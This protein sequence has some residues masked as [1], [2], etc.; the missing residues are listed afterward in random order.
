MQCRH[1]SAVSQRQRHVCVRW[2][3]VSCITEHTDLSPKPVYARLQDV[4]F[5]RLVSLPHGVREHLQDQAAPLPLARNLLRWIARPAER[6]KFYG[7]VARLRKVCGPDQVWE[8]TAAALL[9]MKP[10]SGA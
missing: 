1:T 8:R 2:Q 6:Q 9:A 5:H 4:C 7:D 3:A 10:P